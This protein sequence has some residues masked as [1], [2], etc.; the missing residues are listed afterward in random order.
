MTDNAQ[1]TISRRTFVRG[2]GSLVVGFSLAGAAAGTAL[3]RG[4]KAS[5]ATPQTWPRPSVT[6]VDSFLEIKA[7]NSVVA[8]FG[9]GTA[10]QG[11]STG[12]L[13]MYAD[14]LDVPLSSISMI[15]GDTYLTPDQVG[16]S[17]SNGT[18]TEWVE[19]RRA[20]ATAREHLL[21]LAS[22]K[23]GVPVSSLTVKD[24]VVM[25]NG[26]SVTYG[27]LIGGQKFN[28]TISTTAPQK[29]PGQFKVMGTP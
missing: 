17:G 14:E 8:K 23:L 11:T 1:K 9:K 13:M 4:T 3:S 5:V 20:A 2:G 7:D 26:T 25:G 10:A 28:L 6:Q 24:G 19:V 29:Q 15:V 16:A 22:A 12:V 21:K 18:S 27:Q